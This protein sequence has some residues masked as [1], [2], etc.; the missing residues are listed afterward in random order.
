MGEN[1]QLL[2]QLK[3]GNVTL[4]NNVMLAPMAGITDKAFRTIVK[5]YG[6]GLVYTE[7]I[8]SKALFYHDEKTKLLC[9]IDGEARP[10][11]LQLF[12]SDLEAIRYAVNYASE[13]ADIIDINMGCP[14]PKI[15]KNGDG[16]KLLLNLQL[17][18]KI[19][20]AAVQVSTKPVSVKIRKGWDEKHIVAVETAKIIE[21]AGASAITVHGR[22]R[23]EFYTGH[24]DWDIIKQVKQAVKIPVIGNGDIKTKEDAKKMLEETKVDG[25]M[26]GRASLGNPWLFEE[27]IEYL[28]GNEPRNISN[29]EK[30]QTILR[31]IDLEVEEKGEIIGIRE[32]RKHI[33]AYIKNKKDAAKM[34]DMVN[35]IDT[36][37][38]LKDELLHFFH[39]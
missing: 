18:G 2:K 30:L 25:I 28:K 34:R 13:I 37:Q 16:S 35:Q 19:V 33:C 38:E 22:T 29:E 10:I 23:N 32:L 21:Q 6:V 20:E 14:A 39:E 5:Q 15:V 3:I 24:A 11:A 27:I 31:H 17:V 36:K 12:G 4:E 8:S 1:V 9:N 26:I 7:M